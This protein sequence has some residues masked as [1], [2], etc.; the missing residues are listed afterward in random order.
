MQPAAESTK[1]QKEAASRSARKSVPKGK[2][3]VKKETDR[4]EDVIQARQS[5]PLP[6]EACG[7]KSTYSAYALHGFQFRG[8]TR[9]MFREVSLQL[10]EPL[11]DSLN[12][13]STGHLKPQ[14]CGS[15]S[16]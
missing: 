8:Q 15:H 9:R 10:P 7:S 3:E 16:Q 11:P 1:R 2:V 6:K 5:K 14:A 12:I 13:A 4:L